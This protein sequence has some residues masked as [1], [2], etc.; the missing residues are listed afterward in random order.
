[1]MLVLQQTIENLS[2]SEVLVLQRLIMILL[3]MASIQEACVQSG[4]LDLD[5]QIPLT[6]CGKK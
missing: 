5:D 2:K 1:M 3:V 6:L 4:S